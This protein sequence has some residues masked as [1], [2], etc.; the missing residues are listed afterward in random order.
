MATYSYS[1]FEKAVRD[2]GVK[3]VFEPSWNSPSICPFGVSPSAGVVIHH[4][5]NG[6]AKGNAPSRYW[7]MNGPYKP[8]RAYHFLIG[9]DGTVH[10]M[11]GRGAYHAGAGPSRRVGKTTIP[12]N[13]GNRFLVGIG[14]ESRGTNASVS[15]KQDDVDGITR[16]QV[17]ATIRLTAAMCE[18]MGVG[19]GAVIGHK[20]WAPGRKNDPLQ[21]MNWWRKRVKSRLKRNRLLR[22]LGKK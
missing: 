9:R 20:E 18:L 5:A 16:A 14:I 2:S 10:V 19:A 3:V 7:C 12:A 22:R 8:V 15:A 6:G 17:R 11:S 13:Q 4:T 1:A 21:D